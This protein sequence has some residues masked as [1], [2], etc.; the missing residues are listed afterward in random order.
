MEVAVS[1]YVSIFFTFVYVVRVG[2]Y[3]AL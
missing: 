2:E 3:E 1:L